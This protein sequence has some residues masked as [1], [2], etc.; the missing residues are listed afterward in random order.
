MLS[1]ERSLIADGLIVVVCAWLFASPWILSYDG[2]AGWN[3]TIAAAV[4]AALAIARALGS[5]RFA[6]LRHA[7]WL[8]A[9]IG[10]WLI[11]APWILSGYAENA[12][13]I[14]SVVVGLVVAV[15]ALA[16]EWRLPAAQRRRPTVGG[17][18]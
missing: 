5:A 15:L 6:W 4:I 13:K 12:E 14:N 16:A 10:V 9:L 2:N 7:D 11:A 1:R 3:A 18:I 17:T 8:S